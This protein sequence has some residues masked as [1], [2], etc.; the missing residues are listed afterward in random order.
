MGY[1]LKLVDNVSFKKGVL[2]RIVGEKC[3]RCKETTGFFQATAKKFSEYIFCL[4]IHY[5]QHKLLLA[6]Q[7]IKSLPSFIFFVDGE[8]AF[9]YSYN[10]TR[11]SHISNPLEEMV[12]TALKSRKKI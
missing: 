5:H 1:W 11:S 8:R 7:K 3:P 2:V 6:D 9:F 10:F 4:D 12:Y